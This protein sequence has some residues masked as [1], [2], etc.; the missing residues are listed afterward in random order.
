MR[1]CQSLLG[2]LQNLGGY[3][4]VGGRI[5]DI[6]PRYQRLA[7]SGDRHTILLVNYNL[8]K[9]ASFLYNEVHGITP[10]VSPIVRRRDRLW[11]NPYT[12]TIPRESALELQRAGKL[13]SPLR[14]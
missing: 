13:S 2:E 14:T 1:L 11:Y 8:R 7:V 5:T 10:P 12:K 4:P 9:I 6:Y 3:P